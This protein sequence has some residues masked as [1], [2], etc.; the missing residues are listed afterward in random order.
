MLREAMSTD[1]SNIYTFPAIN[2][3][4]DASLLSDLA[5]MIDTDIYDCARQI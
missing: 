3:D 2:Y 5:N 4:Y 1:V